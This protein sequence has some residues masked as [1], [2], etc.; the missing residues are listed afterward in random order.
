VARILIYNFLVR[1]LFFEDKYSIG[2]EVMLKIA[3][4][5]LA[6]LLAFGVYLP[7]TGSL[8]AEEDAE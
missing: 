3:V 2:G 8:F 6:V 7:G 5:V 1:L 4:I